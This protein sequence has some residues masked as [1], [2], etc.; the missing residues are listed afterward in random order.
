M[1]VIIQEFLINGSLIRTTSHSQALS[2][3]LGLTGLAPA[4]TGNDL[5]NLGLNQSDL[6]VI[7]TIV[8][9]KGTCACKECSPVWASFDREYIFD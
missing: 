3:H 7:S 5:C 2:S 4:L 6:K 1:R 9:C 8:H